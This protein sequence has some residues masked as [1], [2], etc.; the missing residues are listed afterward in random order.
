MWKALLFVLA[1]MPVLLYAQEDPSVACSK[2]VTED[3]AYSSIAGHLPLYTML[4]IS[5]EMLADDKKP[6]QTQR[7]AIAAWASAH[8]ACLQAG[9]SYRA[10][11]YAPQLTAIVTEADN[12]FMVVAADLYNERY[13]FGEA[14]KQIQKTSDDF[15]RKLAIFVEQANVQRA[16]EQQQVRADELR[17]QEAQAAQRRQDAANQQ[18]LAIANQQARDLQAAQ[19]AQLDL[20]RRQAAAQIIMN[21]MNANRPAPLVPYLIPQ[22]PITTTNCMRNGEQVSCTSQ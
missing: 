8:K 3:P 5:F 12:Q 2:A 11:H 16:A 7:K 13:T 10:S 9:E 1:L 6:N 21:N 15:R 18:A 22:R 19:E 14:N 17:V 20:A 4:N